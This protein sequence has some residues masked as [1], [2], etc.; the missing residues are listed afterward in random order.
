MSLFWVSICLTVLLWV[1][2]T[3][4]MVTRPRIRTWLHSKPLVAALL[5]GVGGYIIAA[6]VASLILVVMFFW[7]V[8]HCTPPN[9]F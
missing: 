9:C 1:V 6:C 3:I 2:L 4:I 7:A 5:L 8:Q